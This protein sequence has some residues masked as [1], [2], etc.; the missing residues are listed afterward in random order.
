[1]LAAM[2]RRLVVLAVAALAIAGCGGGSESNGMAG[3]PAD[4][5]VKA[6]QDAAIAATSV[7]I[8]GNVVDNG[9]PLE[10]DLVLVKDTG[11]KGTLAERGVSFELVRVGN[12]AYIKGSDAFLKEFA[13][14]GS[15]A[16]LHDKWLMGPADSGRLGPLTT[17][18][19][20]EKLFKGALS[21]HGKL[22]N[23]GETE[24]KGQKVVRLDDTTEGGTLYVAAEGDPLPVALVGGAEQG[25]LTF[26]EWN[27]DAEVTAPKGAVDITK[28]GG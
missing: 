10:L 7:H 25:N 5:V 18:T 27:A 11:G 23:K 2:G 8:E 12:K 22:A 4:E 21:E 13:G 16:L 6:A 24:Y 3:K 9:A 1:M 15:V 28:L 17:L 20:S 14:E 26:D 19:D